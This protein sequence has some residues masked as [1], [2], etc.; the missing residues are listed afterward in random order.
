MTGWPSESL[1][2][3]SWGTS[4]F[5]AMT[6][7]SGTAHAYRE[8][9]VHLLVLAGEVKGIHV[10]PA[11]GGDRQHH[12]RASHEHRRCVDAELHRMRGG[13]AVTEGALRID[14]QRE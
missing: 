1:I 2:G 3:G 7:A 4:G 12:R 8:R 10:A 11:A 5:S 6:D 13:L 14:V 9:H